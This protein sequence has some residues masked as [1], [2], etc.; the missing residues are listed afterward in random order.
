[1]RFGIELS[2]WPER[3]AAR[4]FEQDSSGLLPSPIHITAYAPNNKRIS[5]FFKARMFF[6]SKQGA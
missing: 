4:R 2:N 1:M 3:I 6:G 5:A